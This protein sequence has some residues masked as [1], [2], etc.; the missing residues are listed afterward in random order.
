MRPIPAPRIGH[1]HGLMRA[2]DSRGRLRMDEFA[3]EFAV[4]DLY[5][6]ELEDAF[7]RTRQFLTYA[8]A[9]GLVGDD[10]GILELTDVG[11]R[12]VRAGAADRRYD[13]VPAQAELLR[14]LLRERHGEDGLY[15]ALAQ[16]LDLVPMPP[17]ELGRA[18]SD[19]AGWDAAV[20]GERHLAL[21]RDL[22][23]VREDGTLTEAG[24]R[25]RGETR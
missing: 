9:A 7:G 6:A 23:L 24:E 18:L 17:V 16:A 4:A 22:E 8:R 1:S 5:P 10:R 12:Y 11:R 3:T 14:G 21:L 2:I 15:H 25:M 19:G 13:V 20:Q